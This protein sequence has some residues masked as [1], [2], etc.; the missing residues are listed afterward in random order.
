[1][2]ETGGAVL[3]QEAVRM[4]RHLAEAGDN[5]YEKK[6]IAKWSKACESAARINAMLDLA[7]S[8][9]PV[10]PDELDREPMLMGV[11]NGTLNLS[12]GQLQDA[13][14]EDYI[15]QQS[16]VAFDPEAVCPTFMKFMKWI[17]DGDRELGI[18]LQS[19]LGY[20]L[21]GLTSEQCLFFA[22]GG[23]ANGK[24]TLFDAIGH[25]LGSYARTIPSDDLMAQ[26]FGGS[27]E[28]TLAR[29]KGARAIFCAETSNKTLAESTVKELSAGNKVQARMKYGHPFEFRPVA[30][31]WMTGNHKPKISGTDNGIWRRIRLIPFEKT[32]T[33][34]E[35][36]VRLLDKLIAESPGILRFC[37]EGLQH[38]LGQDSRLPACQRVMVST[39]EYRSEQDVLGQFIDE[40]CDIADGESVASGVLYSEYMRWSKANGHMPFSQTSFSN[41][42]SERGF[43]KTRTKAM[44]VW[45]GIGLTFD[46]RTDSAWWQS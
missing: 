14:K 25:I 28:A 15:T 16:P 39:E 4:V 6:E 7:K 21:T 41:R 46:V 17:V 13:R 40:A 8:L 32:V 43:T 20:T 24:S 3:V 23:G 45:Q 26:G 27:I 42:I 19:A 22:H 5:A 34:S 12:S 38:F 29:I 18:Y 11:A 10:S 1:V 36:D 33:D 9:A 37:V 30:K 35:R 31:I 2:D 44:M